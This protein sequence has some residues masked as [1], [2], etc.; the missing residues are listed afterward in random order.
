MAPNMKWQAA[1]YVKYLLPSGVQN[2]LLHPDWSHSLGAAG[3]CAGYTLVFLFLGYR[4]F[5]NRDL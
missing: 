4:H 3:A 1:A 2:H 5:A